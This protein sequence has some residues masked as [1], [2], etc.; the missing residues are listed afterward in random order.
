VVSLER[1][2]I[3]QALN[4]PLCLARE[5]LRRLDWLESGDV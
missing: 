2:V 5:L 3:E 4:D 1:P